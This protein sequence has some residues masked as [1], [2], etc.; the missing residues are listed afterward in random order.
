MGGLITGPDRDVV[1]LLIGDPQTTLGRRPTALQSPLLDRIQNTAYRSLISTMFASLYTYVLVK[2]ADQDAVKANAV[3]VSLAFLGDGAE[4]PTREEMGQVGAIAFAT[5]R[6]IIGFA[7]GNHDGGYFA[8]VVNYKSRAVRTILNV[9]LLAKWDLNR[10]MLEAAGEEANILTRERS[11][12]AIRSITNLKR[13]S[14]KQTRD[15]NVKVLSDGTGCRI[16]LPS[17]QN[18]SREKILEFRS[19]NVLEIFRT[20]WTPSD[21]TIANSDKEQRFWECVVNHDTSV[22]D[23]EYRSKWPQPFYLHATESAR[24][25][26]KD[27]TEFPLY[28]ITIDCMDHDKT[29]GAFKGEIS[30]LQ[31]QLIENF[32]E[33]Q[34][35]E[36]PNAHFQIHGHFKA[37]DILECSRLRYRKYKRTKRARE[38]FRRTLSRK[39]VILYVHGHEHNRKKMD[40]NQA[41]NLGRSTPLPQIAVPSTIDNTFTD[42][43]T[44]RNAR[45][46]LVSKTRLNRDERGNRSLQI[47]MNFQGFNQDDLGEAVTPEV[48][49]AMETFEKNHGFIRY[50]D[51]LNGL[52]HRH[53]IGFLK[54]FLF[55]PW[56]F[57]KAVYQKM[58]GRDTDGYWQNFS[59]LQTAAD[60]AAI[61]SAINMFNEASHFIPMLESMIKFI[62]HDIVTHFD[63]VVGKKSR[64][65]VSMTAEEMRLSD[66][67]QMRHAI[68]EKSS[69]RR[70]SSSSEG[71]KKSSPALKAF[72]HVPTA[73]VTQII[74][75]IQARDEIVDMR[76]ALSDGYR[77]KKDQFDTSLLS[78]R[79][80]A[81][82]RRYN[83][84]FEAAKMH[85]L[86]GK[87]LELYTLQESRGATAQ[88]LEWVAFAI[89][90]GIAASRAEAKH[91]KF[92]ASP[93][94]D[95][96]G[97][98]KVPL[99]S[100]YNSSPNFSPEPPHRPKDPTNPFIR[101]KAA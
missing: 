43:K 81:E 2:K 6:P 41:L 12:D 21:A 46:I 24:F 34:L 35:Q 33:S 58:R 40:L 76:N 42:H 14:P 97:T 23:E 53:M 8:G 101:K 93:I 19:D 85:L 95:Q 30:A 52:K 3:H 88:D 31:A 100:Q 63:K 50:K 28:T 69:N 66:F 83:D 38:I 18:S 36:N 65:R 90:A 71:K 5:G 54:T 91:H 13:I 61:A 39:E 16:L 62:E 22:L 37:E 60:N 9:P 4:N 86:P 64:K 51:S 7:P 29:L 87:L 20:F 75:E 80:A 55:L 11:I 94:P 25:R 48:R 32:I 92:K 56:R 96:L 45:S 26:D 98:L 17:E 10:E 84:L 44:Y 73:E 59:L 47:S 77:V 99:H 72:A 70:R 27:G 78:G 89:L 67:E 68:V 79:P 82:T 15:I 49:E 74:R 57:S 1:T